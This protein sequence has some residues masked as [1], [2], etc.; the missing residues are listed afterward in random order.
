VNEDQMEDPR[1][2]HVV[3]GKTP[4]R[5]NFEAYDQAHGVRSPSTW[6]YLGSIERAG[7]DAGAQAVLDQAF[8]GLR[9][10]LDEAREQVRLARQDRDQLRKAVLDLAADLENSAAI[11][12]PSA[13]S[14]AEA[15]DAA[16]LRK[17]AEP[18]S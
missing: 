14:R 17:I 8:P 4:G 11:T 15:S 1:R 2:A 9:R 13:K 12:A 6:D 18:P 10:Q 5:V 7:F 3:S 16:R